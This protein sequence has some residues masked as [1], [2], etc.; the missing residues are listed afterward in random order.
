M[1]MLAWMRVTLPDTRNGVWRD[2]SSRAGDVLGL[3]D[4]VV[5]DDD[6]ELVATEAGQQVPGPQALPQPVGHRD[7]QLVADV[8]AEA[9]VDGL[10]TVQVAVEHRGHA[11]ARGERGLQPMPEQ[12]AVGQTGQRVVLGL[13]GHLVG[14]Q[15]ATQVGR[16][17]RGQRGQRVARRAW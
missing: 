8:V 4:A 1:P 5:R 3:D 6:G 15:A 9:V 10:E 12:R 14:E 13:V 11:A 17:E 16:R 7:E 2:S